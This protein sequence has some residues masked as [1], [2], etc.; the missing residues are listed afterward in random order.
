MNKLSLTI[1]IS[2]MAFV[3]LPSYAEHPG[4]F[5]TA[6]PSAPTFYQERLAR[7]AYI[8]RQGR[9]T[10]STFNPSGLRVG[11]VILDGF[12]QRST[13]ATVNVG[14][15]RSRGPA[16]VREQSQSP[17]RIVRNSRRPTRRHRG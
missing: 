4:G 16:K 5:Q 9:R 1:L 10:Q 15:N 17:Y 11:D 13:P 14:T 12:G 8:K 7:E 2:L 6:K 3:A